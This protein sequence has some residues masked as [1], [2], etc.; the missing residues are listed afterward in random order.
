MRCTRT[1]A[2]L[3]GA[4]VTEVEHLVGRSAQR[5]HFLPFQASRSHWP[6]VSEYKL[7]AS[8]KRQYERGASG[9][10]DA[11]AATSA[12][13]SMSCRPSLKAAEGRKLRHAKAV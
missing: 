6:W 8:S 11:A 10:A 7:P 2:V 12:N 3:P 4:M 9:G 1:L 5:G 13:A